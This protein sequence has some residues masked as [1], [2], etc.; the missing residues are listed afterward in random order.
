MQSQKGAIPPAS[1]M[2]CN[3]N[4]SSTRSWTD[5][6]ESSAHKNAVSPS[7]RVVFI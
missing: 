6:P 2:A 5:R 4:R 3:T 7:T 1:S